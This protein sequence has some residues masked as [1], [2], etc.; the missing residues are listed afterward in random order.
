M[1]FVKLLP[2][3]PRLEPFAAATLDDGLQRSTNVTTTLSGRSVL[4]PVI[5]DLAANLSRRKE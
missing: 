2:V 1:R 4:V 5:A 3:E